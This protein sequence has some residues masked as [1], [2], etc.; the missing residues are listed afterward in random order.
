MF[1]VYI[2]QLLYLNISIVHIRS[3]RRKKT[4]YLHNNLYIISI[5]DTID[6]QIV[7]FI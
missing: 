5:E 6:I 3:F 2:T 7:N 4:L 1:I